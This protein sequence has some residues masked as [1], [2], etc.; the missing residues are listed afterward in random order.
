MNDLSALFGIAAA[1][2]VGAASPGPSF[3]MVA[4]TAVAASRVDGVFAALGMGGGGLFFACL[5]LLGL[6]GL[7]FAIPSLYLA[8]NIVGGLYLAYLGVQIWWAAGQPLAEGGMV[9]GSA[10]R[11]AARSFASGLSTQLSNP[12]TAI[13]YAS[14]F[15]AFLPAAPSITFAVWVAGLVFCIEA[16]WYTLVAVALSSEHSRRV[17]LRYKAWADRTAGGVMVALGLKLAS[18][19]RS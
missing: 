6:Q 16:G 5:S 13:V 9:P 17:Y 3:I 14:V 11:S 7:L 2:A 15:A 12:K 19:A 4:R 8:L 1:L 10:A 18:S